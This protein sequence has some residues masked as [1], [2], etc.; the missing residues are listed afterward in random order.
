MQ[1]EDGSLQ[2]RD[3][4]SPQG[5]AISP[6]LAD[7][8]MHYAFDS[9]MRREFPHID[10]EPYC[11]DA[12]IHCKSERQAMYVR[13]TI[14]QRLAKC[15]LEMHTEKARI[16]YCKDA[17]R[18]GSYEHERFD[19]LGYGFRRGSPRAGPASASSMSP[20]GE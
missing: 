16:V 9:W 18:T 6:L 19:F 11:D 10:F 14:A 7:V 13:D 2:V 5:S 17:D 1:R 12:V 4:G 8:F 3:R 15:R 20:G